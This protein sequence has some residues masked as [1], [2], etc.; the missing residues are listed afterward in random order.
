MDAFAVGCASDPNGPRGDGTIQVLLTDFPLE[1]IE[2]AEVT[3]SRI[4]LTGGGEG[5]VD[6]FNGPEEPHQMEL[7][8]LQNGVTLDLTGEVPIPEG[9]YGQLRFVVDEARLALA[10]GYT[11][12]GG[13]SDIELTVPSGFYRVI[14]HGEEDEEDDSGSVVIEGGETTVVLVDFDVAASFVFQGPLE[15]PIGV[16]FKPVLMQLP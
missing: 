10:D 8:D 3:I 15:S 9:S 5:H 16:L 1:A 6:L 7:L 13:A 2:S 4:Y 11:F 12:A 14:L